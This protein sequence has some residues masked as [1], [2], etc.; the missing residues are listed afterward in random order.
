M[1]CQNF[2][3]GGIGVFLSAFGGILRLYVIYTMQIVALPRNVN[4]QNAQT[5]D[6]R[7]LC[8]DNFV[9]Q[10]CSALQN[11]RKS[12]M[13]RR[14]KIVVLA[15]KHCSALVIS[16]LRKELQNWHGMCLK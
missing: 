3:N 6:L 9:A 12:E 10:K 11:C 4:F 13:R 15:I 1:S 5:A 2:S 7:Q 8:C 14:P 16:K